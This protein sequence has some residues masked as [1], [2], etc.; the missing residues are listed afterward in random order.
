M[1]RREFLRGAAALAVAPRILESLAAAP[2]AQSVV[3][4]TGTYLYEGGQLELGIIRDS[5][6]N[7]RYDWALFRET[8]EHSERVALVTT[9]DPGSSQH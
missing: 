2:A 3:F 6:I 1:K 5:T 7:D 4:P 9:G 8:F